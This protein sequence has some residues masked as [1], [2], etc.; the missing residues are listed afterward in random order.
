MVIPEIRLYNYLDL[1]YSANDLSQRFERLYGASRRVMRAIVRS[2]SRDVLLEEIP[3][4]LVEFGGFSMASV[5][6]LDPVTKRFQPVARH[7]DENGYLDGVIIS[8]DGPFG[9]GPA[10]TAFRSGRSCMVNH[11]SED[12]I[13]KPW[14]DLARNAGW[15]SAMAIPIISCG[16]PWGVLCVYATEMGFFGPDEEELM[17]QVAQDLG[18]ALDRLE[19][20]DV[21]RRTEKSLAE[22]ESRLQLAINAGC[23]GT[24][25][26]DLQSGKIIWNEQMERF[27]GF[28]PG[29]FDGTWDSMIAKIHPDDVARMNEE[30]AESRE[31]RVPG[32]FEPRVVWP[33]GSIHWLSGR[34]EY[35]FSE[36]GEAIRMRGAAVDITG[37]KRAEE[38]RIKA[39]ER[40]RRLL[41]SLL[42]GCRVVDFNWN[43]LYA[44]GAAARHIGVALEDVVGRKMMDVY[45]GIEQT[46]VFRRYRR[47]MEERIPQH[48]E[49]EQPVGSQRWYELRVTPVPEGIFIMSLDIT[50]RRRAEAA[51]E[52]NERRLTQAVQVA[53]IGIFDHDH[54]HDEISWTPQMRVFHRFDEGAPL[55]LE[56]IRKLIHPAD[57]ESVQSAVT[58]AHDP[59]GNGLYDVEYRLLFPDGEVRW[60]R[61]QARTFFDG[62]GG[63][64]HPAH[65]VGAMT[66]ITAEKQAREEERKLAALV[67]M[68]REFIGI[69]EL[70]GRVAYLNQAAMSLVGLG[71]MEEARRTTIPDFVADL[72]VAQLMLEGVKKAG[73][74]SGEM[75]LRHFVTGE[76]IPVDVTG[77]MIRDSQGAPQY[78]ATVTRDMRDRK[79]AEEEKATLEMQ[80]ARAQQ[81]ES[82]GRLAGGVAHDFNNMLTVIL[83][84]A[85]LIKAGL[86]PRAKWRREIENIEKAAQHSKDIT[87]QLLTFSRQQVIAPRLLNLNDLVA[88]LRPALAHLLREDIE[89]MFYPAADLWNVLADPAQ[90]KQILLNLV[91]NARDAMPSGGKLTIQ[92]GNVTLLREDC[93][94][95]AGAKPGH[96][97]VLS[98]SDTGIGM[99]TETLARIFEPFFTTKKRDQGTGLGLATVYGITKQS[100]GFLNVSSELNRGSRF[101]IY[102]PRMVAE[103]REPDRGARA[104]PQ[105]Q[106]GILVMEDDELVRQ[107]VAHALRQIGYTPLVASSPEEAIH[108]CSQSDSEIRLVLTDV[109]MP[110]VNGAQLQERL[111]VLRPDL[112][113]LYMSGYTANVIS[114]HGVLKQGINF[115]QKPFTLEQL[116][117][118]LDE[119][120]TG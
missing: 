7:G 96:Y 39:E 81:M 119:I 58:R 111:K 51:L 11:F 45:P 8:S 100:G 103:T 88:D 31:R 104:T 73:Y 40:Y 18:F 37:L 80:L 1:K 21:R 110:R 42:E 5:L 90:V 86:A 64:R 91:V 105:G 38:E 98:V 94:F 35:S 43:Y 65:T 16:V 95:E 69:A 87:A 25:D 12:P 46:E 83:G 112:K 93:R 106:G 6:W 84:Y 101:K 76:E 79:K 50:E 102:I 89:L 77:F 24:F 57:L 117:Q 68:S 120:L 55:L 36:A 60:L 29:S 4:V 78:L 41:D 63:N 48:F 34:G 53:K 92:T 97:V 66:D 116:A 49:A 28:M 56:N 115:I 30:V 26:W 10:G 13:T 62:E 74:W 27:F 15:K 70:D 52:E 82:I 113:V 47:V 75:R 22:S 9:S 85:A 71:S 44:N 23:V 109:I 108:L 61:V 14:W 2:Q 17:E 20:Q 19:T 59:A 118:K 72:S 3:R 67:A 32:I 114:N 99:G 54:V 33:D 107:V